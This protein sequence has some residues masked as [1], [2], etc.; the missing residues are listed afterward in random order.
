MGVKIH[1]GKK[2]PKGGFATSGVFPWYQKG[3]GVH[4]EQEGMIA[5]GIV[6]LDEDEFPHDCRPVLEFVHLTDKLVDCDLGW[7]SIAEDICT[8]SRVLMWHNPKLILDPE[9]TKLALDWVCEYD[10]DEPAGW[11]N[12]YE[13]WCWVFRNA[14]FEQPWKEKTG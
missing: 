9:R 13:T 10:F 2:P 6:V 5:L 12:S 8:T 7:Y 11:P 4:P 1:Y 3:V 14:W